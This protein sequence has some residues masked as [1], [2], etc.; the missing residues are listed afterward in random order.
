MTAGT[1]ISLLCEL[2]GV[3]CGPQ[4]PHFC[5]SLRFA[6][7][8]FSA[9]VEV[10]GLGAGGRAHLLC[11]LCALEGE[12]VWRTSCRGR[13]PPS[14]SDFC[15]LHAAFPGLATKGWGCEFP[16]HSDA[17]ARRPW[18]LISVFSGHRRSS[19]IHQGGP[20][21]LQ[22]PSLRW[23]LSRSALSLSSVE[24]RGSSLMCVAENWSLSTP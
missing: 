10:P 12:A 1:L 24:A 17:R 9:Q 15:H 3:G 16:S 8:F 7:F 5:L 11:S 23:V 13:V 19:E 14:P 21:W 22:S 4:H 18:C 2:V 20:H 6:S